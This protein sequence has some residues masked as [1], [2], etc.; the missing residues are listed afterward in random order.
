MTTGARA[1]GN[2]SVSLSDAANYAGLLLALFGFPWT[3]RNQKKIRKASEAAQEEARKIIRTFT[4]HLALAT[5]TTLAALAQE[6]RQ[7]IRTLHWERAIDRAE[8]L[9]NALSHVTPT[10]RLTDDERELITEAIDNSQLLME[11]AE[12]QQ[13]KR[14]DT[15]LEAQATK[16]L[17]A[18]IVTLTK[19]DGRLRNAQLEGHHGD[20]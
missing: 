9:R 3:W 10:A 2:G 12:R 6:L 19:I 1:V 4:E 15:P 11:L 7:A 18:L 17:D 14:P 16:T 5:F 20:K 13:R 8:Q